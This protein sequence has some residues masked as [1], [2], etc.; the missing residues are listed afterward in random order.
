MKGEIHN[1]KLS[2]ERLALSLSEYE[3]EQQCLK[4]EKQNKDTLHVDLKEKV[5]LLI[6]EN[7]RLKDEIHFMSMKLSDIE[8]ENFLLRTDIKR[9]NNLTQVLSSHGEPPQ[10]RNEPQQTREPRRRGEFTRER[11]KANETRENQRISG[12]MPIHTPLNNS[13]QVDLRKQSNAD[14]Q[15]SE[16]MQQQKTLETELEKLR[17]LKTM[18]GAMRKRKIDM[19]R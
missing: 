11:E 10:A 3:E 4:R 7:A 14:R 8:N 1:L 19:E 15:L 17:D 9:E 13:S 2:N 18:S 6:R 12:N 16:L 5:A